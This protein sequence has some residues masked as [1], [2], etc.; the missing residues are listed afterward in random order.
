[1]LTLNFNK[2]TR[3][4]SPLGEIFVLIFSNF[5]FSAI[6][7]QILNVRKCGI[8]SLNILNV[9]FDAISVY[10]TICRI[11]IQVRKNLNMKNIYAFQINLCIGYCCIK[12]YIFEFSIK[13]MNTFKFLYN[14]M[15]HNL[16][17]KTIF[18]YTRQANFATYRL[19]LNLFSS[20]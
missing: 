14:K 5:L 20:K 1:M 12:Y 15:K 10:P 9:N 19:S 4:Q 18:Y 2:S 8:V 16:W 6:L 13:N 17:T 11:K 3:V 7:I